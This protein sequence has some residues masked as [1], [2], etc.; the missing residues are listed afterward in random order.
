[1]TINVVWGG[2]LDLAKYLFS[3]NC[4]VKV[5]KLI[6]GLQDRSRQD[7]VTLLLIMSGTERLKT[8]F[9]STLFIQNVCTQLGLLCLLPPDLR[10]CKSQQRIGHKRISG[11]TKDM[12][13]IE[14]QL[15]S[16]NV[17]HYSCYM[18]ESKKIL[19]LSSYSQIKVLQYK[20][21]IKENFL[22]HYSMMHFKKYW[23]FLFI[24][25]SRKIST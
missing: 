21:C 14:Q 22:P 15:G 12:W 10:S 19:Q 16:M 9:D 17:L 23:T 25:T 11:I 1:M 24:H 8:I 3:R 6:I 7:V 2:A 5:G 13:K 20:Y 18:D 4:F